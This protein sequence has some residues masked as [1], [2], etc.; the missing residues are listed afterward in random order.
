M[1]G[2]LSIE[3]VGFIFAD[4]LAEVISVA[5]GMAFAVLPP[6]QCTEFDEVIGAMSLPGAKNGMFF[7]SSSREAMREIASFMT[8]MSHEHIDEDDI[9]DTMCELVNVT[10]GNAALRI[11]DPQYKFSASIPFALA[12]NDV[13]I[14]LKKNVQIVSKVLK[15]RDITLKIQVV[16]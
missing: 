2:A 15:N 1:K 10:G 3:Q 12:G 8:G 16:Y 5:S 13:S 6:E 9:H 4:A 14:V 11:A 7:I